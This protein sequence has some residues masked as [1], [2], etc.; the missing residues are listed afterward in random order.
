MGNRRTK[1]ETSSKKRAPRELSSVFDDLPSLSVP[2]GLGSWLL[3]GLKVAVG[4]TL[5]V[6]AV[7][8]LAWGVH[9]YAQTTPRFAVVNVEIEGTRR[10]ARDD[11]LGAAGFKKGDNLFAL[12]VEK[13]EKSLLSSPWIAQARVIRELPGTIRLEIVERDAVALAAL[14]G[15]TFLV[16]Q[17]GEPFK[18]MGNG[19]PRDLPIVTG[20]SLRA[21]SQDRRAELS[22]LR[23]TLGL[24]RDYEKLSVAQGFPIE[25]V[26]LE[27]SG[28]VVL[29]VG[30]EGVSLHIGATPWKRKLL[31]AERV[32]QRTQ[33]AGGNPSV[34]FL[35]NDAHPERVVVRVR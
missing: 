20:L 11:V 1:N 4:L 27:P 28:D 19:D 25:E 24:L 35:D 7:G 22:R 13:A 21:I 29:V 10:L 18:E 23:D 12:D 34:V 2:R 32:L 8:A 9:R 5:I 14:R 30:S 33:K 17:D 16:S 6:G 3:L 31:R 15:K 26:H